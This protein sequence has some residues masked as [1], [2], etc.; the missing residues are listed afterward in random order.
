MNTHNGMNDSNNNNK[1]KK[2]KPIAVL[3][4]AGALVGAVILLSGLSLIGNGGYHSTIAQQQN[5]TEGSSGN[6][7]TTG[8]GA[9]ANQSTSELRMNLEQARTALQNNDTQSAMM[10]LEMALSTVSGGGTEGN[11]TS[12]TAAGG[13]NATTTTTGGEEA[14]SIGGT[15]VED[16]YD[17][18]A[19]D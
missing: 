11:I 6:A 7:T 4:I 10:Y 17:E 3:P 19:D 5:T 2:T 14:V 18:T 9:S 16:D 8:G 1:N 13:G 12:S 15:G